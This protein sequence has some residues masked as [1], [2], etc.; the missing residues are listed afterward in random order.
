[1]KPLLRIVRMGR[2]LT[3]RL[4]LAVL[5]GA[6]AVGAAI[7]LTAT[8]AWLIDRA[9][10]QPPVLYLMVAI[11]AVRTFGIGRGVLRYGERLAAH[12]AAFRILGDLRAQTYGRL[13]RLAPAGLES[14]RS[15]DLLARLV[16][17]VD[18]LADLWL[19]VLLPYASV[20]LAAAGSVL[21]LWILAPAAGAA[22]AV[23]L[24]ATAFGAPLVAAAVARRAER[25][26]APARGE[27]AAASLDLLAG[28][29]ELVAAGAA[30]RAVRQLAAIDARLAQAEA[31]SSTGTGAGALAAGLSAGAAVW[32]ALVAGVLAVRAG[33]L[34]GV[35]LA[36]VVLTPIAVHEAVA[37]L[38]PAA[39]HLPGLAAAANRLSEVLDRPDPVREPAEPEPLPAGPYGLRVRDLR[40]RYAQGGPDV[41]RGL[42]LDVAAGQRVL[43][44]GPSGSGKSTFAAVLLRFLDPS[45]GTV[46]L[47]GSA[48]AVD[49]RQLAADDV[50]R[51][52]R[53]CEQDP[54]VFDTSI[55]EN[56]RLARPDADEVD[57][58]GALQAAQ[59]WSWVQSLPHGLDT[60]VGEHGARLSAGQ[61]QR[62]ALARALL[63]EAPVLIFDEPTEYLDQA[64][65]ETLTEDLMAATAG[66]TV[67][68]ITHR[69]ELMAAAEWAATLDLGATENAAPTPLLGASGALDAD[70][71]MGPRRPAAAVAGSPDRTTVMEPSES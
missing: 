10:Q 68:V 30:E 56:L 64:T 13:E 70:G 52:I 47:V 14:F 34:G 48:G 63:A 54:H 37:G 3:P 51:V 65:A 50:R 41:L 23:T 22:L 25:R 6:G 60:L 59:L 33:A 24:L 36:V 45:G 18:G 7:G 1:M 53:L 61:V 58:A 35:A 57:L 42:N 31:Q 17:D 39:Q 43:V 40:A 19:R 29:P 67:I 16:D 4:L 69:P 11:T 49:V 71:R 32:L 44:T 46:E 62:L 8:S 55:A 9:A 38:V 27:L 20:G 66:R 28:A 26:I 5:A 15:G 21:L 2:P 12:D